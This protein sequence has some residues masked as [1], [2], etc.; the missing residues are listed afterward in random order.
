MPIQS[1]FSIHDTKLN[2]RG[3]ERTK[4][5]L[6]HDTMIDQHKLCLM[7]RQLTTKWPARDGSAHKRNDNVLRKVASLRSKFSISLYVFTT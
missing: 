7:Y 3:R 4:L 2:E 6:A 5:F 1:N